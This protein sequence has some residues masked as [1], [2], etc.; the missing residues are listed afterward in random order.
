MKNKGKKARLISVKDYSL[1]GAVNKDGAIIT[2]TQ[3]LKNN[4]SFNGAK[5]IM[6]F[7]DLVNLANKN[8]DSNTTFSKT[9]LRY[10]IHKAIEETIEPN[11]VR[12]YQ[13]CVAGLEELYTKL[14]LNGIDSDK[15]DEIVFEKYS[16][17]EKDIFDI[18]K[19]VKEKLDSTKQQIYK[20][21]V[22]Q[23]ACE[24]LSEYKNITFVG[25]VFLN[26]IQE[27]IIR[28]LECQELTFI[29]KVNDFIDNELIEPL[30]RKIGRDCEFESIEQDPSS[31]F[32]EIE[33]K[34]FTKESTSDKFENRVEV[35]EPFSNRD[36][37]FLFIAKQISESIR[38]KNLQPDEL[39]KEIQ[40]HA[41]VLTK[42]KEE[43]SK[44]FNDAL[45]QYGVFIPSEI[46][47][48]NLKPIY[49]SK[50]ELLKDK[51]LCGKKRLSYVEK[52]QLFEN[53]KRI[54][55][56]GEKVQ[57]EDFPIGK[58]I[59]EVYKVVAKDLTIDSFKALIN[60][61]WYLNKPAD[62]NAIQDFYKLEAYFA[63]LTTMKQWKLEIKHLISLK[64]E[65]SKEKDF[66]Y[67]PLFV[68][69]DKSL[70]YIKDYLEFIDTLVEKLKVDGNIKSQI[71]LLISAFNLA[72]LKLPNEEEQ[73]TLDVFID[74]LNSIE[75][76]DST[77]IDYKYFAEHIKELIDQYSWI[78]EN[79]SESLRLPV[80]NMENATKYDNVFFPMFEDNKYPRVLKLEFPY[81]DNVVA[82]LNELG[83]GLQKNQEMGYHLKMSRHIFRNVFGFVKDKIT[84]T[85]T[86]KEKG[87]DI[88]LSIYASDVFNAIG[89]PIEFKQVNRQKEHHTIN[90]RGI[91]FKDTKIKKV[92]INE[93]LGRFMCFKMFYYT[94]NLKDK[95]CY[96]DEF[97][98]NFYAKALVSNRFFVN[99][100]QTN[101]EYELNELFEIEID[102]LFEASYNEI[103][104]YFDLF[105]ENSKKDI[106]ITARKS[107]DDFIDL[108]IRQG[109]FKAKHF[110]FKLGKEKTIKGKFVVNARP[111]LVMIN[112]DKG[113]ET[114]FDISKN[115][116]YLVSS[117]GGRK[118]NLQ[119]FADIIEKLELGNRAD[120][121]MALV[122]FAS[123]KVNTQL[124]N[125]KYYQDGIKRVNDIIESTPDSYS[126]INE[127]VSSY[128]R[129]CKMKGIC[130]GVLIDD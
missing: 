44:V 62:N 102:K 41:I 105:G 103:I 54:K 84:F 39:E 67:H 31:D 118:H 130:K 19:R 87:T 68:V 29:S 13:N 90:D 5:S 117:G 101:K 83:L 106:K 10:I 88:G 112:I 111:T 94:T 71:K 14:I 89:R 16:F 50:D 59:L 81:T 114:E 60:T 66:E 27:A 26:D 86:T 52:V 4:E 65:I 42:N 95:I 40:N 3:N 34:L 28:L 51:I 104:K 58:F 119:H 113:I 79:D 82:I 77:E 61:Q 97:L 7:S 17:V 22:V 48:T 73:E 80:V 128:C 37:E 85:F 35:Y 11:K 56:T 43:L 64:K 127:I 57:S 12:T 124:N 47:N 122:N 109:K 120:D 55:V 115:L 72:D 125:A 99:L 23:E 78:K 93:L 1:A 75:S 45:G 33:N 96:K 53:F 91:I 49:Y 2:A 116:D 123:F 121:K 98:L 18:Y 76:S 46:D 69:A 108:H 6:S 30:M 36:E 74:I 15:I 24:L 8:I 63:N 38:Q 100:A 107:V 92:N 25:F 21:R 9:E 126:N 110:K 32:Y 129:F 20:V 70:K